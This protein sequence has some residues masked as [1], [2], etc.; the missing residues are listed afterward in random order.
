MSKVLNNLSATKNRNLLDCV[1]GLT[2]VATMS[3]IYNS[4]ICEEDTYKILIIDRCTRQTHKSYLNK[5]SV[6]D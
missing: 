3:I 6:E 4:Y 5:C 1:K 2:K